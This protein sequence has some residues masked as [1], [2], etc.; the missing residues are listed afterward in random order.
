MIHI[1][2]EQTFRWLM[3]LSLHLAINGHLLRIPYRF[4]TPYVDAP[5]KEQ[6]KLWADMF[7]RQQFPFSWF[8]LPWVAKVWQSLYS[9][10]GSHQGRAWMGCQ[11]SSARTSG[12]RLGWIGYLHSSHLHQL[13]CLV[14]LLSI[15][16]DEG[17]SWRRIKDRH[18]YEHLPVPQ[19][20]RATWS[21][22][23]YHA[24][25]RHSPTR[26]TLLGWPNDWW[27]E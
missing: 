25:P 17:K 14:S 13:H 4:T 22:D 19:W 10:F 1:L 9:R 24:L 20:T 18:P 2:A 23:P 26:N 8:F 6:N 15:L 3:T 21:M 12:K 7:P 27:H 11:T 5:L 16:V